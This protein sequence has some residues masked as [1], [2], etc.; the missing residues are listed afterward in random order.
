MYYIQDLDTG[1]RYV[2]GHAKQELR[3][4]MST[5]LLNSNKQLLSRI[6]SRP[7]RLVPLV[8]NK[9]LWQMQEMY[10]QCVLHLLWLS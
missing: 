6:V 7:C 5:R 3:H 10:G 2:Q 8:H 1:H 4:A 9:H